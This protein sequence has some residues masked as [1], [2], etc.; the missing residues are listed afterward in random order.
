MI[1]YLKFYIA[2][3][4]QPVLRSVTKEEYA[5]LSLYEPNWYPHGEHNYLMWMQSEIDKH[6]IAMQNYE[7][8]VREVRKI[9]V[10]DE[11]DGIIKATE[12]SPDFIRWL[13][14]GF[15]IPDASSDVQKG[16][17]SLF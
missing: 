6:M 7:N 11:N 17:R 15:R 8:D 3:M 9:C 10:C 12:E 13:E 2:K 14:S 16:I 4:T 1:P 5:K